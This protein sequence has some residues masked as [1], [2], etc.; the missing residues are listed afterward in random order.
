MRYPY[1]FDQA[2]EIGI[3][4]ERWKKKR[5]GRPVHVTICTTL[6]RP[7]MWEAVI[8]SIRSRVLGASLSSIFY[9]AVTTSRKSRLKYLYFRIIPAIAESFCWMHISS[10]RARI[11]FLS[12]RFYLRSTIL[13]PL[14]IILSAFQKLR[15]LRHSFIAF[16][17]LVARFDAPARPMD[18]KSCLHI[19]CK[20][21]CE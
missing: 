8:K 2:R 11:Q 13:P 10:N 12:F 3:E 7:P 6:F 14:T 21:S 20:S 5:E 18:R 9:G 17:L 15:G 4:I 16:H 1:K 19:Q